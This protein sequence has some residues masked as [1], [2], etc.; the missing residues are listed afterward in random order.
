MICASISENDFRFA[1]VSDDVKLLS[2]KSVIDKLLPLQLA[3]SQLYTSD[4]RKTFKNIFTT[5]KEEI[6]EP[7][8]GLF[9]SI[10]SNWV[11]FFVSKVDKDI[12]EAS[13][14]KILDWNIKTRL[15][16]L[17]EHKF[18]QHYPL[19]ENVDTST[20]SYLTVSYFKEF[21]NILN[22]A[23]EY[24]GFRI[25]LLDVNIFNAANAIKKLQSTADYKRWG[26]WLVGNNYHNLLVIDSDEFYQFFGLN[27]NDQLDVFVDRYTFLNF[28]SDEMISELNSILKGSQKELK[29][30]EQLYF[31]AYENSKIFD[32]LLRSDIKNLKT[33]DPFEFY[34]PAK[35]SIENQNAPKANC[36][37]LD[38]LGSALRETDL[39]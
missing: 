3:P 21:G 34:R 6:P 28:D 35:S 31:Y 36:Q 37:F 39:N 14:E 19:S 26:I 11:D 30:L 38:V 17:V 15:G 24:A 9:L 1:Q 22:D 13:V 18:I 2:I 25:K 4:S 32:L 5:I 20:R 16:D 12:Q 27:I 23:A 33:I 8:G 7:E 10:P 29:S